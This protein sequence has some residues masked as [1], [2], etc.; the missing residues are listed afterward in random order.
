[1]SIR[2]RAVTQPKARHGP[3]RIGVGPSISP[4][5]ELQPYL[6]DRMTLIDDKFTDVC[7]ADCRLTALQQEDPVPFSQ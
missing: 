7:S 5:T 4:D 1:M 3:E 6:R 2:F